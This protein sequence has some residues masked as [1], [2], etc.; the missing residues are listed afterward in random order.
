[1]NR[2]HWFTFALLGDGEE[3]EG[4]I[5][6]AAMLAN[7]YHLNNLIVIVDRNWQ[8]ATDFTENCVRLEPLEDKWKSFGWE[9]KRVDGHNFKEIF[10]AIGKFRCES[11]GRPLCIIADT[12]KGKGCSIMEHKVLW[13]G[14]APKGKDAEISKEE[15][16]ECL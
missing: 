15:L 11:R 14:I 7:H 3:Y 9:V 12:V 16:K 1:M 10:E 5:W 8:C 4:S 13:H 6:E 2:E